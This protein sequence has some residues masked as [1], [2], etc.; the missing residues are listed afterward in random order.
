[1]AIDNADRLDEA[2]QLIS[3]ALELAV[4]ADE[5]LAAAELEQALDT[6]TRRA[7]ALRFSSGSPPR[8][9]SATQ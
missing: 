1:M 4:A 3:Q 2:R 9:P 8:R 5:T 6:V 7:D